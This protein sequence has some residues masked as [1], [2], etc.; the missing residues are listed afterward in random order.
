MIKTSM[1]MIKTES[2]YH[3]TFTSYQFKELFHL[4]K[5]QKDQGHLNEEDYDLMELYHEMEQL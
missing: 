2:V 1:T 4:L 3:I 5:D